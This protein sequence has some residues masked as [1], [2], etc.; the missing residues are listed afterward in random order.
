VDGY[1]GY[2]ALAKGNTVSLA[3]C[4]SHSRRK[5]YDLAKNDP[6]AAEILRRFAVINKIEATL[7][8]KLPE[9]RLT[10][11]A[12]MPPLFAELKTLL[13]QNKRCYSDKGTMVKAIKYAFGHWDGLTRFLGDGRIEIGRVDD[14]RGDR[15]P[16]GL[17]VS[18][19]FRSC[20]CRSSHHSSV[21]SRRSSNRACGFPAPGFL[22]SHQAF[23]LDRSIRLRGIA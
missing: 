12:V 23:A 21:S 17:S 14:W 1:S 16:R 6:V 9:E 8:G 18:G 11:R 5:F 2:K 19:R 22:L 10:G 20:R 13:E 4:L 3:I 15:R 7:K